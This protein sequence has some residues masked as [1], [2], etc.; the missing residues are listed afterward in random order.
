MRRMASRLTLG[1]LLAWALIAWPAIAA[2]QGFLIDDRKDAPFRM[3]RPIPVPIVPGRPAPPPSPVYEIRELAFHATLVDQVAK[4]QV[5]Q[6]FVNTGSTQM[7]VSF[8]FPLPADAAIDRLT[9]MV[10]GKEYDGKLLDAAEARRIYEEFMR[11]NQ[12]PALL[13]WI[14][15]GMFRTSVFPVPAGAQRTVTLRYSQVCRQT[16]GLT[17]LLAPMSAAKYTAKPVTKITGQVTIESR[18]PLKNV[19]SPSHP[20][21]IKR[22]DDKHAVVSWTSAN[23]IP[24]S[25]FRLL[26]DVGKEAVGASV[27]SYRPAGAEDGYFLLLV[28]PEIKATSDEL[29]RK[30]IVFVVDRSGSM[31]GPKIEQAKAALKFVLN[32]LRDGDLFNIVAYDTE[33]SSFRPELQKFSD[34]TRKAALG[35]VEGLYAGGSTNIDG[36]L[37]ASLGQLNDTTRPNYVLFLT[38][39][40]PTAGVVNEAQLVDIA[41]QRNQ[42]RARI[43]PFGVGYDVNSRLLDK[44]AR[45]GYGLTEYVRPNEDIEAHVARLYG[46]IG[47]PVWTNVELKV[48]VEG[49]LLEQGPAVNRVY[50]REVYDLFAGEQLVVVGRYKKPGAA[51]ITVSG[52]AGA[53]AQSLSFPGQLVEKSADESLAFIEKLWAARR[54]GE[55]IDQIDLQGR[56][57]ELIDELISLSKRHGILT[58]YTSFL[59][60]DRVNSRDLA[61]TRR[62]AASNLDALRMEAGAGGFSQRANKG[63]LQSAATAPTGGAA[64][65]RAIDSDREV[66][67]DTVQNVGNKTFFRRSDRW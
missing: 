33:V 35:F 23:E 17:E 42:V 54:V 53:Q 8:V 26:F 12:D 57:Q 15:S 1:W 11:R 64:K 55:I 10:D 36:A 56:N 47:A 4:V 62:A 59:A 28:T 66:T 50:P 6:T 39:G 24:T 67:V 34:E 45:Q 31:S 3:P 65:F 27:L 41:K 21:E 60:D 20:V 19:Y 58:P 7:E 40:I 32:N 14:G 44:I 22:P 18:V 29:P 37:K 52:K 9:F 51:K 46:R 25:D 43:F 61:V 38:D 49:A 16:S 63:M 30:N 13:E 2:A 5:T 48:D